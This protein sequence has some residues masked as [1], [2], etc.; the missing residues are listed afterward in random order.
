ME[1]KKSVANESVSTVYIPHDIHFSILS[2]LPLKSFKRFES[3]RKSWSLLYENSLF[4]NMFHNSLLSN[5]YYEGA[6][7]L[8]RVFVFDLRRY[9]LYSLSG[10]NF[11]NKVKLDAPDSFLNHIRLRIFGF[12]SINGTFCLHHYD[13]KG[14]IS[15][16]NPTTQSIKLLPPSEVESVGSSIPDF[17]QGFVTL[18]VMSCIHGFSYDHVINDYKVIRYVRIIVLA[19]FEYPGDVEDVMDLLADISL[20][21]WEIYSSKSNSWREL[22]VDMPYSLDCNAGTQVYMDGV[23]H[24]L[25]EK[26]EENPIGPCLV[27]FYLSNEVFVTTPIPSDVDDC[28]DVKENWINLAVLNVSIALMSYHEGTTTFHISILGEFGIKESWTKIFIVGPLSGVERPIGV[29]TK[30]EIFFLRKDEELVWLDL[31]TQRI[32][33]LGYKGV[34]HTSRIIIYKDNI[35]PIGG[36]SK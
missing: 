20:A 3:V 34:G 18:S 29:G 27:S 1:K 28:F 10:E 23:C 13:N 2:K 5:S 21:P 31:S 26:H 7:L 19:S 6:S 16:W 30:G 9:V 4:M 32:A 11:E 17:A 8:L 33:G 25:C 14:Q 24:W 12:G 15:L 35:L 36:T 22:D